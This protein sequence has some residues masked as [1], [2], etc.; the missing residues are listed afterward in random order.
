MNLSA[1]KK[2]QLGTLVKH[3]GD[4]NISSDELYSLG[5]KLFGKECCLVWIRKHPDAKTNQKGKYSLKKLLAESDIGGSVAVADDVVVENNETQS[6][7]VDMPNVKSAGVA[8][9][10][11]V[12][13]NVAILSAGNGFIPPVDKKYVTHENFKRI[14]AVINSGIF[15]PMF[16][17]GLS[18]NGKT[19]MIEQACAKLKRE[20]FRVNITIETDEDDL[21]GGFRLING[22]TVW[23]DGPVIE[24]MNRGGVLLLDEIDLASNKIMCLQSVL[25]G[26]GIFLKKLSRWVKPAAGFTV[27]ATANTKGKGDVNGGFIG[28]N[29]LNEAFLDRFKR[30][31]YQT[32]PTKAAELRI[33]GKVAKELGVNDDGFTK[34]LVEWA[35]GVR[36]AYDEQA[37]DEVIST[38]RL[39]TILE[40]FSIFGDKKDAIEGAIERFDDDTKV[41]LLDFYKAVDEN[42]GSE[43]AQAKADEPKAD[44]LDW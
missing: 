10:G 27:F 29:V 22:D 4:S 38:R 18:G 17:T 14:E 24:A 1:L 9:S 35:I 25:E 16:I 44:V 43:I 33:L 26:K 6:E 42:F 5:T 11:N 40:S 36:K 34:N 13:E 7:E 23:Q 2:S 20:Y 37:V 28:T 39:V 41:A 3:R 30:T 12:F 21:L 32:Y 15:F 31:L 8:K 19:L